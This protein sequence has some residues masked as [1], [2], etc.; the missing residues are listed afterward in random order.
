MGSSIVLIAFRTVTVLCLAARVKRP[1]LA[2][3]I[4][5]CFVIVCTPHCT[6]SNQHT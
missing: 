2:L 6:D 5:G 4:I 3:R 1:C